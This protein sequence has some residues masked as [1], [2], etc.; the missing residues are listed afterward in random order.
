MPRWTNEQ[1]EDYK[2]R[3]ASR[4]S[5]LKQT[6]CHESVAAEKREDRDSP[7]HVV[8]ITSFRRRLL[9]ADNLFGGT[10]YFTDGLRHAGL[11]PGDEPD[12][13]RLEVRQVKVKTKAEERTEIEI[14]PQSPTPK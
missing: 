6:L 8:R 2:A 10:K 11:I 9:D 3:R 5:Q 1:L 7:G 13:I 12:V 14:E 4:S